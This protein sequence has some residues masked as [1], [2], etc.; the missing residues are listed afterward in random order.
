MSVLV[1]ILLYVIVGF[2]MA[3][4]V[5]VYINENGDFDGHEELT[6]FVVLCAWPAVIGFLL[7]YF[8]TL[9][10]RKTSIAMCKLRDKYLRMTPK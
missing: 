1:G 6:V 8:L 7:G 4:A 3:T 2:V 10:I 9:A 5:G